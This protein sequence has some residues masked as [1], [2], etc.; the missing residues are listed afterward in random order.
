MTAR[1]KGLAVAVVL[2]AVVIVL[3]PMRWAWDFHRTVS[4]ET[5]G[6]RQQ[7]AKIDGFV[8]GARE[9]ASNPARWNAEYQAVLTAIPPKPD[10]PQMIADLTSLSTATGVSWQQGSIQIAGAA[11]TPLGGGGGGVIGPYA[12]PPPQS[13]TVSLSVTGTP[14][15]DMAF[16]NG[17]S[18]APRL[19]SVQSFSV[20]TLTGGA[21]TTATISLLAYSEQQPTA[22]PDAG[23]GT[24]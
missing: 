14:A 16:I 13:F 21:T 7:T 5:S 20:P 4:S 3:W 22:P 12:Y 8:T 9:V 17:L 6:I 2:A 11:A 19:F 1:T 18:S 15:A 10:F 24:L 23:T